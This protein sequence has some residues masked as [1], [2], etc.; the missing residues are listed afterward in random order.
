MF[1]CVDCDVFVGLYVVCCE[2]GGG[3][4][5]CVGELVVS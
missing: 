4:L 5:D 3:V 1:W 2:Y